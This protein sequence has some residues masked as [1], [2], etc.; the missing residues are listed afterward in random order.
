MK[1][2]FLLVIAMLIC[3]I[4]LSSCC[5]CTSMFGEE[6]ETEG[7]NQ[8]VSTNGLDV[9]AYYRGDTD[10]EKLGNAP[11]FSEDILWEPGYGARVSIKIESNES[12]VCRYRF[13]L[14]ADDA[15]TNGELDIRDVI[16][17]YVFDADV[18]AYGGSLVLMSKYYVGTLAEFESGEWNYIYPGETVEFNVMIRMKVNVS[19]EYRNMSLGDVYGWVEV[20]QLSA[21]SDGY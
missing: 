11:L 6:D 15:D 2:S 21:E 20:T 5:C 13:K 4:C 16:E 18:E 17:V 8:Y 14:T 12:V 3:T 19:D 9:K 10:Y 7:E 1:Q